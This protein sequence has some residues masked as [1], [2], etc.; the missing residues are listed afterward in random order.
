MSHKQGAIIEPAQIAITHGWRYVI[1]AGNSAGGDA[2]STGPAP[3]S[4]A[5]ANL[6]IPLA[7]SLLCTVHTQGKGESPCISADPCAS[8]KIELNTAIH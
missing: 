8:T 1:C 5:S 4:C 7:P 2:V 6:S 3:L